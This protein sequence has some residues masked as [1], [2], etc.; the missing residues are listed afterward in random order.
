MSRFFMVQCVLYLTLW[1]LSGRIFVI[2]VLLWETTCLTEYCTYVLRKR[3]V[4]CCCSSPNQTST[5]TPLWTPATSLLSSSSSRH[6]QAADWSLAVFMHLFHVRFCSV[7]VSRQYRVRCCKS[8]SAVALGLPL[9]PYPLAD[10]LFR[11][12]SRPQ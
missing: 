6:E 3:Y 1:I 10:C 7:H 12:G 2:N 4:C 5:P 11:T 8:D 9:G